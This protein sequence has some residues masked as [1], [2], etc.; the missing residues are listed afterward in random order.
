MSSVSQNF[1]RCAFV[2]PLLI[3]FCTFVVLRT[4]GVLFDDRDYTCEGKVCSIS[5]VQKKHNMKRWYFKYSLIFKE[6][7]PPECVYRNGTVYQS[8]L[9]KNREEALNFSLIFQRN[10]TFVIKTRENC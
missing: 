3:L 10:S 1:A 8:S 4:T 9:F 5:D 7:N 2:C 6:G